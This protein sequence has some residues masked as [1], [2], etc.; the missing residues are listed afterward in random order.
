MK[1]CDCG[2]HTENEDGICTDCRFLADM[3]ENMKLNKATMILH[4][5]VELE[6]S[7]YRMKLDELRT[8]YQALCMNKQRKD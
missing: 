4:I 3:G 7:M 6:A 1:I 5:C 8:I 2:D